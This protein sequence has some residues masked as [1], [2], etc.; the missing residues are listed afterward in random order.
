MSMD[1]MENNDNIIQF[2]A[3]NLS[4]ILNFHSF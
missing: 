1:Q 4:I 2:P 3:Q